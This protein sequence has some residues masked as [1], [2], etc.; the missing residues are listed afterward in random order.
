VISPAELYESTAGWW[1]IRNDLRRSNARYAFC[2]VKGVIREVYRIN[3]WRQRCEGDRDWEHDLGKVPRWGF[4]GDTA[5]QMSHYG[6]RSVKHLY[7]KRDANEFRYVNCDCGVRFLE[8]GCSFCPDLKSVR[9]PDRR[10]SRPPERRR[11]E[12]TGPWHTFL[13][14]NFVPTTCPYGIG[15]GSKSALRRSHGIAGCAEL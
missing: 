10:R 3:S 13:S 2:V 9:S 15:T 11:S 5:D 7:N 14:S 8:S 12:P 6:K 1:A 4:E